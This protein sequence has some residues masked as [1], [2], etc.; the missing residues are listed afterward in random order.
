MGLQTLAL[1]PPWQHQ[2]QTKMTQM[3][4]LR[5]YLHICYGQKVEKRLIFPRSHN[6]LCRTAA[7]SPSS[8][9]PS[10]VATPLKTSR[11]EFGPR[12]H[13]GVSGMEGGRVFHSRVFPSTF[14]GI[15]R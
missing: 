4:R 15:W 10:I 13:E 2:P 1:M 8:I 5:V 6:S 12:C 11:A 14:F 3:Q 7:N 9:H